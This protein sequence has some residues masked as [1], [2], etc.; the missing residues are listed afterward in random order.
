MGERKTPPNFE[1]RKA[2]MA[3]LVDDVMSNHPEPMFQL[4][5]TLA[6]YSYIAIADVTYR[7]FFPSSINAV[8]NAASTVLA[9]VTHGELVQQA[10]KYTQIELPD[11]PERLAFAKQ[12]I[13]Q[14]ETS[15]T[16]PRASYLPASSELKRS[17]A[18]QIA[19]LELACDTADIDDTRI[20]FDDEGEKVT[21]LKDKL[22]FVAGLTGII[23]KEVDQR[24]AQKPVPT[25]RT[26]YTSTAAHRLPDLSLLS[27]QSEERTLELP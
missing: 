16:P 3:E 18:M 27:D 4:G 26:S 11:D 2:Q 10:K 5:W 23:I 7:S 6:P 24:L 13:R 12:S 14:I 1:S 25:Q 20:I 8:R 22:R 15:I 21:N 17:L 19:K 9:T